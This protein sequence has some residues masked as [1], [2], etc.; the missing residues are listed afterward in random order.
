MH[1]NTNSFLLQDQD[2]Q[3]R[4][5]S[6][7]YKKTFNSL[8]QDQS[9]DLFLAL[10]ALVCFQFSLARSAGPGPDRDKGIRVQLSILSCEI[11][12]GILYTPKI[13]E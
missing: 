9:Q 7:N 10:A 12:H 6:K 3:A 1:K 8:L 4:A 11:R 5:C 2:G 13:T